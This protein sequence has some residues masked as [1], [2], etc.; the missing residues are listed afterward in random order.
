MMKMPSTVFL[1]VVSVIV[2][3]FLCKDGIT[4]VLAASETNTSVSQRN[5]LLV[6]TA[7]IEGDG[8]IEYLKQRDE[9]YRTEAFKYHETYAP[10][11]SPKGKKMTT[12]IPTKSQIPSTAPSD[13]PTLI[14]SAFPSIAPNA[15]PSDSPTMVPSESPSVEPSNA[16]TKAPTYTPG[17]FDYDISDNS[18]YGP[19]QLMNVTNGSTPNQFVVHN[20]WGTVKIPRDSYWKEFTKEGFGAWKGVLEKYDPLNKNLCESGQAQ[21]PIDVRDSGAI[22]EEH[23]EVRSRA[24]DYPLNNDKSVYKQ[25]LPTKLRVEYERRL[26]SD[27]LK[28][29]EPDPPNG[30]FPNGWGGYSD[31]MHLDVKVPSEHWI[32]GT[33]YDAEMQVNHLH[34]GNKRFSSLAVMIKAIPNGY[35]YYFQEL[36]RN[37]QVVYDRNMATCGLNSIPSVHQSVVDPVQTIVNGTKRRLW[38]V[39]PRKEFPYNTTWDPHHFMLVP[40]I[41]F[42]RYDG[43][44]TEPPCSEFVAWFIADTPMTIGIEQLDQLKRILFTNVDPITCQE[45][46]VHWNQSVARPIRP[47]T[48]RPVWKCTPNDFIADSDKK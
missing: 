44:I 3:N 7:M 10:T 27:P 9:W 11:I 17:Y 31:L 39:P 1:F 36:L 48:D 14:P 45:T 40:S 25:I 24:G 18:K 13:S 46:S 19:G 22:C 26:C 32:D 33:R 5:S 37:F 30:D 6:R 38:Q 29:D 42:Y 34:S 8:G 4:I 28:C 47:S 15:E 2:S 20:N 35:N 12:V 16:P 21:S 23:H 41:W 43:S